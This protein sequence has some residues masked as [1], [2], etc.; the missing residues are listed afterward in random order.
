MRFLRVSEIIQDRDIHAIFQGL[1]L[2][3]SHFLYLIRRRNFFY[4][5]ELIKIKI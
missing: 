1:L 5:G 4:T 2:I 3:I